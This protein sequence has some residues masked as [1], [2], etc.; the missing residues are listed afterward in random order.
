MNFLMN[1]IQIQFWHWNLLLSKYLK[2]A[3]TLHENYLRQFFDFKYF[4]DRLIIQNSY[5]TLHVAKLET[6]NYNT[7]G[8]NERIKFPAWWQMFF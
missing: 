8:S 3:K 1:L 4:L 2:S 5:H 7:W 6:H